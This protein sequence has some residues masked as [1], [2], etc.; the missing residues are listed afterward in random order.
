MQLIRVFHCTLWDD[1]L[2]LIFPKGG[3]CYA[4]CTKVSLWKKRAVALLQVFHS[5]FFLLYVF[6][7][8]IDMTNFLKFFFFISIMQPLK[9]KHLMTYVV[10]HNFPIFFS[11]GL[12]LF[13]LV[14]SYYFWF[15]PFYLGF[16]W[17]TYWLFV[18]CS[19]TSFY[20]FHFTYLCNFLKLL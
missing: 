12:P 11:I 14:I 6:S 20:F 18:L 13:V 4:F 10:L 15:I 5:F 17:Y 16:L 7:L 2:N 9:N 1:L 3:M 19:F 8:Y